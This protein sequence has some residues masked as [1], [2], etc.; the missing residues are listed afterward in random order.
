M[1]E[2][3]ITGYPM[4]SLSL[5]NHKKAEAFSD[6]C[7][8]GFSK[9]SYCII[10]RQTWLSL[11]PRLGGLESIPA[12]RVGMGGRMKWTVP[13]L[14]HLCIHVLTDT[15]CRKRGGILGSF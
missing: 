1:S 14:I 9:C 8:L 7:V 13:N 12:A 11:P 2:I 6:P 15:R 10:Y 5:G 4:L 3:Q